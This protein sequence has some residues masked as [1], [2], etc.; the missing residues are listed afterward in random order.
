MRATSPRARPE[1]RG[2]FGPASAAAGASEATAAAPRTSSRVTLAGRS[3]VTRPRWR[4]G[5]PAWPCSVRPARLPLF[6]VTSP[7][8]RGPWVPS[9]GTASGQRYVGPPSRGHLHGTLAR[10]H[11]HPVPLPCRAVSSEV[12]TQKRGLSREVWMCVGGGQRGSTRVCNTL[13][14][15]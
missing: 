11:I 6:P 15:K 10:H 7:R 12:G 2:W 14:V 3:T 13:G 4:P 1:P 8:P 5:S 9:P